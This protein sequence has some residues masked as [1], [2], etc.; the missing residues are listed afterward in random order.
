MLV[1][2]IDKIYNFIK[3][4][5]FLPTVNMVGFGL[6]IL[7]LSIPKLINNKVEK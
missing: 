3:E 7:K 4:I 6:F 5:V 1:F 2:E